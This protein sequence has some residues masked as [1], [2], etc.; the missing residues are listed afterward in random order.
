VKNPCVVDVMLGPGD[1]TRSIG[2]RE[3][4]NRCLSTRA[5]KHT[6]SPFFPADNTLFIPKLGTESGM[7]HKST[8]HYDKYSAQHPRFATHH[9]HGGLS[10]PEGR[11]MRRHG[12]EK[13][14]CK[15]GRGEPRS[16]HAHTVSP[17]LLC[18][19]PHASAHMLLF[20]FPFSSLGE[21]AQGGFGDMAR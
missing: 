4:G 14:R 19:Q 13:V 16:F 5:L 9:P 15:W 12:G 17:A 7:A 8:T 11:N 6:F 18:V 10:Q 1:A 21:G 2:G 20:L 3:V